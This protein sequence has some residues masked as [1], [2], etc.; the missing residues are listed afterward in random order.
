MRKQAPAEKTAVPYKQAKQ[1]A[2]AAWNQL[3]REGKVAAV[4]EFVE[5]GHVQV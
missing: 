1:K 5:S 2:Y 3:S 4:R